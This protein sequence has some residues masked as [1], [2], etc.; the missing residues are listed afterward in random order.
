MAWLSSPARV[1]CPYCFAHFAISDCDVAAP[2]GEVLI[3]HS[4]ST[5]GR[6][7]PR[8]AGA[9]VG[10]AAAASALASWQC[11]ACRQLL[12][13]NADRA[14]TIVLGLAGGTVSGKSH[15]IAA[16]LHLLTRT[17]ALQGLGITRVAPANQD[18]IN[19][20]RTQYAGP[21]FEQRTPLPGT[22]PLTTGEE[23]LPLVYSLTIQPAGA[24]RPREVNL[25]IFD[26]S[27]EQ[28]LDRNEIVE[29]DRY[30]L[31]AAAFILMV[32]PLGL[33]GVARYL[34]PQ[35]RIAAPDPTAPHQ[36]LQHIVAFTRQRRGLS[37]GAPI[38]VPLAITV[39]KAD[40]L[41]Y[42]P[43]TE[44]VPKR[45]RQDVSYADGFRMADL[46]TVSQEVEE[47]LRRLGDQ[48]LLSEA[49]QFH[50]VGYFAVSA[51]GGPPLSNGSF[52]AVTP[53]RCL[54][55]LVWILATLGVVR[56]QILT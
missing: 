38:D 46:L 36:M 21:L 50:R 31:H 56:E 45:L 34:P 12:P 5:L 11:P 33:P 22:R 55:P 4:T 47:V 14:E 51:T 20:Y 1:Q 40:L 24:R 44:M 32:D 26:G 54:D 7:L 27:G 2:D 42:V 30:I 16:L 15:Y 18:V 48:Q 6:L 37:P 35:L 9:L 10:G 39:A 52:A 28:L 3:H 53:I 17:A 29:F 49:R 25:V 41:R 23:N 13:V 8:R 43:R 19:R